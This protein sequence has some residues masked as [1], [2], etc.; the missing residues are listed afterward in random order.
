MIFAFG[1]SQVDSRAQESPSEEAALR[2]VVESYFAAYGKKDLAGVVAL[3][4]EKS[5]NLTAYR[6]SLQ[7]QF[8]NE[9]LSY[10][11]PTVSRVKVE[12]ERASLRVTIALASINL[13]SQQKSDR[14]LIL[15]FEL[16]KEAGAWKV[17]RSA[18]A[19]EDLAEA[20]VKASSQTEQAALLAEER[21]LVTTELGRALLAQGRRLYY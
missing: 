17:W 8:T 18:S 11:S 20:L 14:Q 5:P 6:Q 2:A 7:Q 21:E 13:K 15:S 12:N 19:A 3:W 1:F 16:V 10:G 9:D 4:S